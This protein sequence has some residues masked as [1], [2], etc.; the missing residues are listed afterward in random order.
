MA[1]GWL[2]RYRRADGQLFALLLAAYFF[3]TLLPAAIA[4]ATYA[5]SDAGAVSARLIAR[6]GLGGRTANLTR[7][8][9]R[10]AGGHRSPRRPADGAEEDERHAVEQRA[11][12]PVS[13]IEASRGRGE[14]VQAEPPCPPTNA[15]MK[16]EP[17][18]PVAIP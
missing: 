3:V 17:W 1:L 14:S 6:L 15:A 7:D 8:V 2:R 18:S 5:D 12:L 10:R 16:P 11:N 9:L 4:V 13:S